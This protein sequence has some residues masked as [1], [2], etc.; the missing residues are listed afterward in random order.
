MNLSENTVIVATV[1]YG[2]RW[3]YLSK[4]L[5]TV[6]KF[7]EVSELLVV[8]NGCEYNLEGKIS[9]LNMLK[10]V[11][12]IKNKE[13][14]GSAG[15]YHQVMDTV[16]GKIEKNLLL[17]DDD[18]LPEET[19]FQNLKK[20]GKSVLADNNNVIA[21]YRERYF[22]KIFANNMVLNKKQYINTYCKFSFL[23]KLFPRLYFKTDI[24]GQNKFRKC[25]Y[26]QYSGLLFPISL[27]SKVGL[28]NCD[29][30][31][32]VDDTDF[33]YRITQANYN[34][35]VYKDGV[36]N[37]MEFSW[38]QKSEQEEIDP[39]KAIFSSEKAINGL[40]YIRNRVFFE[41]KFLVKNRT[42]YLI[43][44]FIYLIAT[45]LLYMPKNIFGLRRFWEVV[46][47]VRMGIHGDLGSGL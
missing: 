8:D 6:Q 37:E 20:D 17:L 18:N 44:G 39:Y 11:N 25:I 27:L 41:K 43:N 47:A 34:I 29:Y 40:Y 15:G 1:T 46:K 14:L 45:F 10:K 42:I 22:R 13:N 9:S 35:M 21:F 38:A 12:I 3:N 19:I 33:T 32:Y 2:N 5:L 31:L 28:P 26:S 23:H 30:Y 16:Q 7:P 4:L 24:T 36:I